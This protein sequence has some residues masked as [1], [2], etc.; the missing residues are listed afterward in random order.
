MPS[1]KGIPW[2]RMT[3]IIQVLYTIWL[4][5]NPAQ[6]RRKLMHQEKQETF[7][8]QEIFILEY[9]GNNM[10]KLGTHNNN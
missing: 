9:M 3:H 4:Q 6:G 7:I 2:K 1:A 10:N 5:H 8:T